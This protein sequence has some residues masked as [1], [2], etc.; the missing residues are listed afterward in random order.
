MELQDVV[1]EISQNYKVNLLTEYLSELAKLF[2]NYYDKYRI[3]DEKNIKTT[4][5]RLVLITGVK[6]ALEKGLKLLGINAPEKM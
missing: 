6:M 2:H 1:L 3:I 4:E 5:T